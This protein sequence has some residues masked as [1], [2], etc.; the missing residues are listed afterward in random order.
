MTKTC[1]CRSRFPTRWLI[2][3]VTILLAGQARAEDSYYLLMF[4]SQGSPNWARHAHS[5]ATFVK[6]TDNDGSGSPCV[7]SHTISWLPANLHIKIFNILPQKGHNFELHE[8][9][10]WVLGCGLHV[11]LWGPY[12]IRKELYDLALCQIARLE[13]GS[14]WYKAVD[15]AYFSFV[16]CNCMHAI[17]DLK[18][19]PHGLRITSPGWGKAASETIAQGLE[20][21]LIDPCTTHYWVAGLFGLE[22]YP[23]DYCCWKPKHPA[24]RSCQVLP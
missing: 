22:K 3:F 2:A 15:T 14:L 12:Q 16:A 10:D 4:S 13:T 17:M 19:G 18:S 5:F 11:C 9:L 7:E 21:W 6:I 23:L 20:C 8:T 1:H 24:N